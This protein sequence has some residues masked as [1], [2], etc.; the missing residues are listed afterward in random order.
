MNVA[1]RRCQVGVTGEV[2]DVDERDRRMIRESRDSRV[3]LAAD[4]PYRETISAA[5]DE[6]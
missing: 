4:F 2:A 6:P 1:L 5:V 3:A